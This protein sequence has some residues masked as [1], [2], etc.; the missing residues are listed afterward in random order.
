MQLTEQFHVPDEY[1]EACSRLTTL[2]Q[3]HTQRLLEDEYWTGDHLN[4]IQNHA[5]QSYTVVG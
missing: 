5:G 4:A 1:H 3:K 2:V